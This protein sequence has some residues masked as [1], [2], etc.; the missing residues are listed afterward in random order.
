ML[1][2][3]ATQFHS[4]SLFSFDYLKRYS[5]ER[6]LIDLFT[7]ADV[8]GLLPKYFTIVRGQLFVGVVSLAIVPWKLLSKRL[9]IAFKRYDTNSYIASGAAFITFLGSYNIFIAPICAVSDPLRE[10]DRLNLTYVIID[11]HRRL[12]LH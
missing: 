12:L 4:V 10:I 3:V 7:G 9:Y 5:K 2:S 8:T 11:H 1:T 6:A